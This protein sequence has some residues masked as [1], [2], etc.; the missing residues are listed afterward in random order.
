MKKVIHI[1]IL[2]TLLLGLN[3]VAAVAQNDVTCQFDVIVQRDDWLS[4][5][6]EKFY[7]DVLAYQPIADATNAKAALDSSYATIDDVDLIEI[8]WKLCIPDIEQVQGGA[9]PNSGTISA[10]PTVLKVWDIWTQDGESQVIEMLDQEFEA[11]NPGVTVERTAKSFDDMKA[12]VQLALSDSDGPDVVQVYQGRSDLVTLAAAGLL[13][14]LIPYWQKYAWSQRMP[15]SLMARNRVVGDG[16]AYGRGILYGM[17]PTV[18]FVGIFYNKD[19]FAAA[20]LEV[21]QTLAEFEAALAQLKAAGET[22]I[23]FGNLD[24]WPAIHTFGEI[25]NVYL[26]S[27]SYMDNFVYGRGDVSFDIPEN[28]EAASTYKEWADQGYFTPDFNGVTYQDA[29]D[30][31]SNGEGAMFITGTWASR[32]LLAG[33]NADEMGFFLLP[34]QTVGR[35]ASRT[36]SAWPSTSRTASRSRSSWATTSSRTRSLP[37]CG[38]T[39]VVARRAP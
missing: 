25:E 8:G 33:P 6:S 20:N 1:L 4:K 24:G 26:K 10:T 39:R 2:L 9:D 18:E 34:P 38:P 16:S 32:D 37:R 14:D 7:G 35:V 31:F 13:A 22:P 15:V 28:R 30:R 36:R 29:L 19:K 3:S 23:M 5:L 27:R 21:P 17:A 12:T 11:A